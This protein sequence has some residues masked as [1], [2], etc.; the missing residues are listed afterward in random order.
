MVTGPDSGEEEVQSGRV[1]LGEEGCMDGGREWDGG[2][3]STALD[4]ALLCCVVVRLNIVLS[5][6]PYLCIFICQEIT[7]QRTQTTSFILYVSVSF[8]EPGS[9]DLH[10]LCRER[11]TFQDLYSL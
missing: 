9:S 10:S 4:W 8:W 5:L 2:R 6:Y 7:P 3:A 11:R 1:R